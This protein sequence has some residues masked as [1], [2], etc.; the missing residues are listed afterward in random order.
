MFSFLVCAV[1]VRTV[2]AAGQAAEQQYQKARS[3]YYELINSRQT[4]Q[5]AEWL[6]CIEM[7][8]RVWSEHPKTKRASDALFSA[9][10]LYWNMHQRFGKQ[11]N[12][13]GAIKAYEQLVDAY[14]KSTLADDALYNTAIIYHE[15]M[16]DRRQALQVLNRILQLYPRG[17]MASQA[18][19]LLKK[20]RGGAAPN[21]EASGVVIED[22]RYWSNP[23]YTRVSIYL[24][25][26]AAYHHHFLKK[27]PRLQTPPRLY[28]D[29]RG[30]KLSAKLQ[31][32]MKLKDALLQRVRSGQFDQNVARVVLDMNSVYDYQISARSEPHRIIIDVQGERP[33]QTLVAEI[34]DAELKQTISAAAPQA[35]T[36]QKKPDKVKTAVSKHG[37]AKKTSPDIPGIEMNLQQAPIRTIVI[38]PGHGGDDPGA[39]G[40]GG[41]R[42]K[43]VVLGIALKLRDVLR[44]NQRYKVILTRDH[45]VF[46]PL[47]ERSRLANQMR[48]DLFISIHANASRK[49]KASGISTYIFDDATDEYS[50]RLAQRE[51]ASIHQG[52]MQDEDILQRIFKSM[53]K[54]FF[55][56]QSADLASMVQR[57]MVKSLKSRYKKVQDLGVKGAMFYVLWNTDMPAILVETSFITNATEERRLRSDFYQLEL[58]KSLGKGISK[59]LNTPRYAKSSPRS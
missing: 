59:F 44:K 47:Q 43:A 52:E 33:R 22:I 46:V 14:P 58:A 36:V 17:D 18:R 55:T 3:K 12:L 51:N 24:S 16:G 34:V 50:K 45:D 10:L 20:L 48:G 30:A 11:S 5:Q 39:V 9:G 53:S 41:T 37:S 8:R 1:H 19:S 32:N 49:R 54:N 7:F 57:A 27:D 25:R 2:E 4:G 42:E 56:Y 13:Y 28:V 15:D 21:K 26:A 38:D 23:A 40:P 6:I 35:K 31:R 29:V